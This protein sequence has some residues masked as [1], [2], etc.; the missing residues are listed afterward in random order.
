MYI[1]NQLLPPTDYYAANSANGAMTGIP[2]YGDTC[3]YAPIAEPANQDPSNWWNGLD[4]FAKVGQLQCSQLANAQCY[5]SMG[6]S[7]CCFVGTACATE[8][9]WMVCFW[10]LAGEYGTST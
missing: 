1:N 6:P 2:V 7:D 9:R 10:D 5:K 4:D 8:Q 3:T